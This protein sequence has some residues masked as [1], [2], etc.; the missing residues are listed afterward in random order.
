M[1]KSICFYTLGCRSN[2][3]ETAILRNLF[4]QQG[5]QIVEENRSSDI[6]VINTCTVTDKGDRDA[7]KLVHRLKKNN[8][9]VQVAMI[10]CQAQTQSEELKDLP[11]VHWIVGNAEKMNLLKL[12]ENIK[13][14]K[15]PHVLTPTIPK[16]SF[17]MPGPGIDKTRT[18]ANIKIQ[19]GCE[20]FCTYCEVP[21]ARGGA[22]SRDFEDIEKEAK[23]LVGAGHKELVLTGIN[24]GAYNNHDKTLLDVVRK[25]DT[26]PGLERIRISSIEPNTIP[27]DL[28]LL[29][30]TKTKLCRYL[31]IPIQSMSDRILD[32]MGRGY[33]RDTID[34]FLEFATQNVEGICI[35]ADI[36]VGFPGESEDDF[37]DT[38][39]FLVESPITYF[40][41][42]SYSDRKF[43][44]SQH[45]PHHVDPDV[46]QTRNAILRQ[47][48]L[49]KKQEF[50]RSFLGTTQKVL[51]EEKKKGY[52]L[53]FTD[54]Y[55]RVKMA[56]KENL[57]NKILTVH[58]SE[59]NDDLVL[60]TLAN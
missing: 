21:Y 37:N 33:G 16:K 28:I 45:F 38:Y 47:L 10:G 30:G 44:K 11:G 35:G 39:E 25:L 20:S 43:A 41:V 12:I 2:Q 48:S 4:E 49:R 58:L 53:G 14:S 18:R 8:P 24:I 19:D 1:K 52:W 34:L 22:R 6:A 46:I 59:I 55:I 57:H 54:N 3:S 40:H 27:H 31:H 15:A 17:I 7:R 13:P 26:L 56:S 29:M 23:Q 5:Y 50:L 51:F 36:I 42:F 60:G 9:K 32:F